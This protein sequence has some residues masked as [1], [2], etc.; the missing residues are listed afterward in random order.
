MNWLIFLMALA[1]IPADARE[2]VDSPEVVRFVQSIGPPMSQLKVKGG[3]ADKIIYIARNDSEL[4]VGG[5]EVR[6]HNGDWGPI[7]EPARTIAVLRTR[8]RID[9]NINELDASF[10]RRTH[11]PLFVM[12]ETGSPRFREIA[13][14][15]GKLMV[16]DIDKGA[17]GPWRQ[18]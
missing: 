8:P 5:I 15:D 16:R 1:T 6:G 12:S 3:D 17:T 2:A 18:P 13:E 10:V 4:L 14:H 11:V 7:P 9:P